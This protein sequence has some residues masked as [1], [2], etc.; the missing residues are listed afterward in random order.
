V[1]FGTVM[2]VALLIHC[3][4]LSGALRAHFPRAAPLA[5]G[6][7]ARMA[8]SMPFGGQGSSSGPSEEVVAKY[9]LLGISD[10]ANYDEINRAYD[11][12]A[13]KY[14]GDTKMTIKLQV[15]KD[16]IFDHLLRQRMSGA[17][18]STVAESPFDRKE[19]KQP[20]IRIPVFLA[21]VM[22]LPTQQYL[23]KNLGVF[24]VIG[25]LPVLS[26]AW[27]STAV[28]IGFATALFLLYNRGVP[29]TSN[30]MDADMRPPKARP[31]LLATGFTLLAGAIGG[32]F[33]QLIYK[34]IKFMAQESVIGVCTSLCF[35]VS[36]TLF[37]VQ[38]E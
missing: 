37:K 21:D 16:A 33:S 29:D 5:R 19:E 8:I 18:K 22:E 28:G 7:A 30:D 17:L 2:R 10:D 31:L 36:A 27:A 6:R 13:S 35:F 11:D 34:S 1:R 20:M 32:T 24:G 38:D 15:A 9:R 3:F 14:E 25:L 23:I 12:L 4:V 26:K